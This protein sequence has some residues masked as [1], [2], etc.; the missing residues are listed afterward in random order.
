MISSSHRLHKCKNRFCLSPNMDIVS[1]CLRT[2]S[3]HLA[4]RL[5][6]ATT[7]LDPSEIYLFHN[8]KKYFSLSD[9]SLNSSIRSS[10]ILNRHRSPATSSSLSSS[11]SPSSIGMLVLER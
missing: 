3:M 7:T 2:K 10:P 11:H 6:S 5:L 4:G 1:P 8:L 9:T